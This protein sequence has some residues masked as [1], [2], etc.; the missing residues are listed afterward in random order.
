MAYAPRIGHVP[1][2][3][4]PPSQPAEVFGQF[5]YEWHRVA[6]PLW[7]EEVMPTTRQ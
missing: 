5:F 7:R 2:C 4:E 1:F 6:W 3:H